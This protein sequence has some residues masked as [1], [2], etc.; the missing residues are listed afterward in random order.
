[1][2]SRVWMTAASLTVLIAVPRAGALS[3]PR[4]VVAIGVE[5]R[6]PVGA[7]VAFPGTVG[8]VVCF[9]EVSGAGEGSHVIHIWYFGEEERLR[10]TL[11]V[12]GERWRTWS[13]KAI[14]PGQTGAWRVVIEGSDGA[15]LAEVPFA[16]GT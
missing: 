1:M 8:Q 2:R 10:V 13:R 6:E 14:N 15:M 4:A 16:I 5:N 7:A 9:S 3:V 12:R 11:P